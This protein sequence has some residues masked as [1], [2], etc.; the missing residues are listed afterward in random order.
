MNLRNLNTNGAIIGGRTAICM[1]A[2]VA[3]CSGRAQADEIDEILKIEKTAYDET[4]SSEAKAKKPSKGSAS[5]AG[6]TAKMSSGQST[7]RLARELKAAREEIAHLRRQLTEQETRHRVELQHSHYNMGCVYKAA[8][9]YR[10]AE[11]E[12]LQAL[13]ITPEDASVH[14]NLGILYDDDLEQEDKAR[15]HY[16]KYVELAPH[17]RDVPRVMEWLASMELEN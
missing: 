17:D 8:K 1:V 3:I 10:R 9:Q 4:R 5:K 6:S 14:F 16:N 12:F 11:S 7:S 2:A 15:F 13:A